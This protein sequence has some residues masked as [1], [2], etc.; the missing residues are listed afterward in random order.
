MIDTVRVGIV[1]TSWWAD[2]MHLP[3]LV[4]HPRAVAVALCGR[5]RERAQAMATK[6]AI[7]QI[8]TDYRELIE[9]ANLHALI[10]SVPDDLH[11]DV[12]MAALDA[13]LHVLCE[14]PLAY[15]LAQ[16]QAMHA[17]AIA[18]RAKTMTYFTWRGV[19][20]FRYI[21][22]LMDENFVGHVYH[23]QFIQFGGYA[24]DGQYLWRF[25][26]ARG[27]GALGDLG[28]HMLDLAHWLVGDI[29][30]VSA[31]VAVCV[32][33]TDTPQPANDVASLLVQF[34][35]GTSG[36]IHVSAVAYQGAR[37][38]QQL[39]RLH[40][41]RGTLDAEYTQ[42][43]S[44]IHGLR[45]DEQQFRVLTI[46]DDILQ[47]VNPHNQYDVFTQ[48]SQGVRA[49]IDAILEDRPI[50]PSFADG[51][52]AQAVMAAAMEAHERGCWVTITNEG[53]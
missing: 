23:A 29:V 45:H 5:D 25:D 28:S 40:G 12:T 43:Y 37:G 49:F 34:A 17:K 4:S 48:Q 18:M 1:G 44:E 51:L 24:R 32:A 22:R 30:R 3:A 21:K 13:G 15:T 16:A 26:A 38:H 6:Y 8:Y 11:Y 14:K 53:D 46:P 2:R 35:D 27:N 20:H 10:V 33:R 52:K 47:G 39:L 36:A 41:D 7:P 31:Q 9:R 19:P 42:T 50:T